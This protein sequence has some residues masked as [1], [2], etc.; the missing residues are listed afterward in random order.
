MWNNDIPSIVF[1]KMKIF[2]GE[3]ITARYPNRYK[4]LNFTRQ[5]RVQS[6][7][8]FPTVMFKNM[9]GMETGSDLEGLGIN[10]VVS[11]VQ[12]DVI[13]N[14]SQSDA[15]NVADAVMEAMKRM[16]YRVT[17]DLILDDSDESTYRVV[18][19]YSREIGYDDIL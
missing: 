12:I 13:T 7:A 16:R 2:A 6:V 15:Y 14:S 8:K 1:T 9:Q 5:S 18:A 4:D 17:G 3:I 11:N 10:G 19:R